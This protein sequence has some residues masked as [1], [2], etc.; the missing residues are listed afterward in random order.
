MPLT[1]T[2]ENQVLNKIF[3]GTDFTDPTAWYVS[4]HTANPGDSGTSEVTGGSYA[5]Q[6]CT[7]STSS[8]SATENSGAINFTNMPATTVTHFAVW[9]N[10]SAGTIWAY[11]TLTA[12][13][14]TEAGDTLSFAAGAIDFTLA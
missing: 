14:T 11:G 1:T 7:F 10:V 9:D 6:S 13:K 12:S 8:A 3:Q 4:L 5:R 2:A